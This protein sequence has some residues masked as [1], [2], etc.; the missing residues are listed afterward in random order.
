MKMDR[1]DAQSVRFS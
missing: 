1:K